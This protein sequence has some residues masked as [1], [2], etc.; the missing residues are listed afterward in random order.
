MRS[1]R[2]VA[3]EAGRHLLA[4]EPA[5]AARAFG[6]RLRASSGNDHQRE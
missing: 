4:G 1:W 3:G 2:P 5:D 6:G